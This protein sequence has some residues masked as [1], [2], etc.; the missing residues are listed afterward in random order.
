MSTETM[1]NKLLTDAGYPV[2]QV[3]QNRWRLRLETGVLMLFLEFTC[4]KT[5]L[6][7]RT[8]GYLKVPSKYQADPELINTILNARSGLARFKPISENPGRIEEIEVTACLPNHQ[9][10]APLI[11]TFT[12]AVVAAAVRHAPRLPALSNGFPVPE[13]WPAGQDPSLGI[14]WSDDKM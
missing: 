6:W 14:K 7:I 11:T 3:K 13:D 4:G 1:I 2:K 5:L 9:L 10:S 8:K 12:T